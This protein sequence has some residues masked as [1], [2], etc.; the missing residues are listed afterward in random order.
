MTA[1]CY[2]LSELARHV[3]GKA[4]GDAELRI[5]GTSSINKPLPQTAVFSIKPGYQRR[6][7]KVK[8]IAVVV[9][10]EDYAGDALPAV[11][12]EDPYLA[13]ARISQLFKKRPAAGG[14]HPTAVIDERAVIGNASIGPYCTIESGCVVED[15]ACL[16]PNC[17]ILQGAKIGRG[18]LLVANVTLCAGTVLGERA[19]I[20]PGAVI[21]ADGFGFAETPDKRW[22]KME[23]GGRVRIGNNVEIGAN[24]TIDCATFD[25]TVIEDGV[26]IDNQVQIAHN[27]FIGADT[28]IAGCT[29]IAGSTR[30]GRRCRIGGQVAI[31]GHIE[32]C[33]DAVIMGRSGVNK[34]VKYSG[35]YSGFPLL[36]HKTWLKNMSVYKKLHQLFK[37]GK[38]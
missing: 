6:L 33:D 32:I 20:H 23:Q 7:A 22:V 24:A 10:E 8:D 27:V 4:V 18:G 25:E 12:C 37:G 36:D 11:I 29:C 13:F 35:V 2:S 16:G 17:T 31:N 26:K 14:V 21:G 5:T 19:I 30:I 9:K 3:N 15:G 34:S 38:P 28:A 1:S